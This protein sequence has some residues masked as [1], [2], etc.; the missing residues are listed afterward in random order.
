MIPPEKSEDAN[1]QTTEADMSGPVT[2]LPRVGVWELV[3]EDMSLVA[4]DEVFRLHG[5]TPQDALPLASLI[6]QYKPSDQT[7]LQHAL[8]QALE[9]GESWDISLPFSRAGAGHQALVQL[10][11]QGRAVRQDGKTVRLLGSF[12]D[13]TTQHAAQAQMR[14]LQ[15]CVARLNDIVLITDAEPLDAPGP[16]IVFVND[17]F[18]RRTGYTRAEVM[19]KSPRILQGPLTDRQELTRIGNALRAWQPVRAELINY[20][21]SGE[22]FWLELDIVPVADAT[23]WFTHWISVE[24]DVTERKLAEQALQASLKENARLIQQIG[25]LNANLETQVAE[26]TAALARQKA[27]FHALAEQAPQ[28]VWTADLEGRVTYVNRAWLD[29]A[30]GQMSDWA[31]YQWLRALHPDDVMSVKANW[32]AANAGARPYAGERRIRTRDGSFLTMAY[33]V[34]P[35]LDDAGQVSFWVGIDANISEIKAVEDA[36]RLSNRELE[37]FSYSVSHDLRAPLSTIDGFSRLLSKELSRQTG[38][39][40][41]E[42]AQHFLSRMQTGV[43]KMG[44]LIEDLVSLGQLSRVALVPT[45]VDLSVL[46]ARIVEEI[47]GDEPQRAV[48]LEI[49]PGLLAYG[50]PRLLRVALENLLGNAFK[51]TRHAAS[52]AIAI[53]STVNSAG[54]SEFFVRDNGAGFDMAYADKL[55]QPFSRLHVEA[56]FAG[57]GIGLATVKRVIDRHGGVIVAK[58]KPGSG[59]EF[60]FTLPAQVNA[61]EGHEANA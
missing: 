17:A 22:A 31:G 37:A 30:G 41:S 36:L 25:Q 23:G 33:R 59:A 6:A 49:A 50:D 46:A 1:S 2:E 52:P 14:L 55:F 10:R 32:K 16:R 18:E 56:D 54:E 26:R 4:T 20:T 42:K 40:V 28:V 53:G 24:R 51:F 38:T 8:G 39:P 60:R 27:L 61:Q 12:Q 47:R 57:T 13:I 48:T 15:S 11:I 35:V 7:R 19:G 21:K 34:A 43:A 29:I 58:A 9:H 3:L 44:Q 5:L 45:Q